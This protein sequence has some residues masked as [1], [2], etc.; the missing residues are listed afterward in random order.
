[1]QQWLLDIVKLVL[2]LVN[3]LI[4]IFRDIE[5]VLKHIVH[6]TLELIFEIV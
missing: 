6:L 1:M 4:D 2:D 3:L 5:S